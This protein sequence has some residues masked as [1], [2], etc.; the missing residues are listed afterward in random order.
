[1]ICENCNKENRSLAKFCKWCGKPLKMQ[2]VLDK[3]VGLEELKK[4]LKTIVDTYTYLRSRRDIGS[5]RLA[6]NSIIIGETV[7]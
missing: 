2:N 5:I 7:D 6:V 3:L 4:Q 1:M